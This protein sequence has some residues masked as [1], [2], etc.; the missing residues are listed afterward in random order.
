MDTIIEA[1]AHLI[2]DGENFR[3]AIERHKSHI[4]TNYI[5]QTFS[6]YQDSGINYIRDGGDNLMLSAVAKN[7]AMDYDINYRTPVFAIYKKG[8][9]GS[10]VGKSFESERD[11]IDLVKIVK[12]NNGDF[13]KLMLSGILDFNCYEKVSKSEIDVP[14][15][16]KIIHIS[17]SEGF[18]VMAHCNTPTLIKQAIEYGV[19]SIEHGFYIDEEGIDLMAQTRCIWVPTITAVKNLVEYNLYNELVLNQI[20]SQHAKSLLCASKKNVLI[21]SGSDA[22]AF[23]VKHC[24]GAKQE[25]STLIDIGINSDL[26]KISNNAIIEKF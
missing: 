10:I 7:Y 18:S 2:L 4:D 8:N 14:L 25:Y 23:G 26:I 19:D 1:H 9:Y 21:A 16:K 3:Q 6:K 11:F 20:V 13:I 12:Q 15:L 17:H 22:G 5:M 24:M